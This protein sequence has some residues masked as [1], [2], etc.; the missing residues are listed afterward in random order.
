MYRI[1]FIFSFATLLVIFQA[2]FADVSHNQD[3]PISD[4][5][6]EAILEPADSNIYH[7][8]EVLGCV[9]KTEALGKPQ[10]PYM[11]INDTIKAIIGMNQCLISSDNLSAGVYFVKLT[12]RDYSKTEKVI[13]LR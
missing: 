4:L 13:F 11:A 10:I 12:T 9:M 2:G 8:I 6:I 3:F 1:R 5:S 7:H